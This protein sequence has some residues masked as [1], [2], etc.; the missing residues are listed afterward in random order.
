MNLINALKKGFSLVKGVYAIIIDL[1][2][3]YALWYIGDLL[4]TLVNTKADVVIFS[5]YMKGGKVIL[6]I[7]IFLYNT[8]WIYSENWI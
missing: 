4:K 7:R 3:S 8:F 5:P 6:L 1:D 2:L